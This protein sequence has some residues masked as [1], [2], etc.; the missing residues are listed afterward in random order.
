MSSAAAPSVDVTTVALYAPAQEAPAAPSSKGAD[1]F[2][3]LSPEQRLL[4]K[5]KFCV[6]LVTS[7]DYRQVLVKLTSQCSAAPIGVYK[8]KGNAYTLT[9]STL[10]EMTEAL[11]ANFDGEPYRASISELG[12]PM[13]RFQLRGVQFYLKKEDVCKALARFGRVVSADIRQE[14]LKCSNKF[15]AEVNTTY[16]TDYWLIRMD[17]LKVDKSEIKDFMIGSDKISV[18]LMDSCFSC[19]KP[20]H[21]KKDCPLKRVVNEPMETDG[22]NPK[23][24]KK[25]VPAPKA[26]KTAL[27]KLKPKETSAPT[28]EKTKKGICK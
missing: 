13:V 14:K 17:K 15:G 11:E 18:T 10:A 22:V 28:K 5:E 19:K 23:R 25:A 2:S 16:E 3:G 27:K 8:G 24:S 6:E 26:P 20:G 12:C 4:I 7:G 9:Y 1:R 21:V